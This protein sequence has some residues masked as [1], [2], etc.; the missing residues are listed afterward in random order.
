MFNDIV[1][2]APTGDKK[3]GWKGVMPSHIEETEPK[4]EFDPP[5]HGSDEERQTPNTSM[6]IHLIT[7]QIVQ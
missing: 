6:E 5:D 1:R 7:L 2:D 3:P 4:P